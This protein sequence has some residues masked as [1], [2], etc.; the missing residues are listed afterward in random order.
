MKRM[1]LDR[2]GHIPVNTPVKGLCGTSFSFGPG[3]SF[4]GM[5]VKAVMDE[6]CH[7]IIKINV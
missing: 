2:R 5:D 7:I 4:T 1:S 6:F 3:C